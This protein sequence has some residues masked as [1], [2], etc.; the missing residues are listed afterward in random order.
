[1]SAV[2]AEC[3]GY[4]MLARTQVEGF[5]LDIVRHAHGLLYHMTKWPCMQA[6][7]AIPHTRVLRSS[8]ASLN[9]RLQAASYAYLFVVCI[10]YGAPRGCL[11]ATCSESALHTSHKLQLPARTKPSQSSFSSTCATH[12]LM[13]LATTH[14]K[15]VIISARS[16]PTTW[17]A[18]DSPTDQDRS[19]R[20]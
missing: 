2:C 19:S 20:N 5:W 16:T 4:T 8:L 13:N 7:G 3:A 9:T 15:S 10:I 14:S 18:P 17:C 6:V 12:D 1:M 11:M